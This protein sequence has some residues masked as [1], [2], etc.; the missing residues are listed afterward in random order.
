MSQ[1]V[2]RRATVVITRRQERYGVI[3]V[4]RLAIDLVGA[5]GYA[6]R[7]W[8]PAAQSNDR[9]DGDIAKNSGERPLARLERRYVH[10]IRHEDVRN[11]ENRDGP[12]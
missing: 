5:V 7:E 10:G 8:Q 9:R 3:A 1:V 11:I 12:E 4:E 6:N 2:K